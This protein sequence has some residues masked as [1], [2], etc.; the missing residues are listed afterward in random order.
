[1]F[2]VKSCRQFHLV[3]WLTCKDQSYIILLLTVNV[4]VIER[5]YG[6][7]RMLYTYGII[8]KLKKSTLQKQFHSMSRLRIPVLILSDY[9]SR[10]ASVI[11]C[12][13]N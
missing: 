6:M 4:Y 5:M 12:Y 13:S 8:I 3:F 1:M 10:I 7:K 9:V 2:Y 11:P